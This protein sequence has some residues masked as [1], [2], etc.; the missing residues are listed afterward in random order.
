M[1]STEIPATSSL[2]FIL[3]QLAWPIR[4]GIA[5]LVLSVFWVSFQPFGGYTPPTNIGDTSNLVNQIGFSAM[6]LLVWGTAILFVPR[7][8]FFRMV[9]VSWIGMFALIAVSA[10]NAPDP[11][12]AR[13]ALTFSVIVTS[14]AAALI[15]LPPN[16]RGLSWVLLLAGGLVL[17]LSYGGVV[18]NP[19][20]AIHQAGET[21][22]QHVGLWRGVFIHKNIAGPVMAVITFSGLYMLRR[23]WRM[24]GLAFA[25]AGFVFV[26][27]TGSKTSAALVP[28]VVLMV[29]LPASLGHRRLGALGAVG[30][31]LIAHALT[32]GTVFVPFFDHILRAFDPYTTFTGRVEIWKFAKEYIEFRPLTGY[33]FAG[34]W[35]TPV[36]FNAER[37]FDQTWD[38]RFIV[39]SHNGFVDMV[40]QFGA[41]ALL[42]VA[43][44]LIIRPA[45]LYARTLR[46]NENVI[47]ADFFF[48]IVVFANLNAALES[49]YFQR[50]DPV[51]LSMVIALFGLRMTSRF[52]VMA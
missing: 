47:L 9:S 12:A 52:K 30:A 33:G 35:S 46:T 23:G 18:L 4:V 37:F 16:A 14:T 15:M 6:F 41:L 22:G 21:E 32:A 25:I 34:F 20:A 13:R 3:E 1:S 10:L 26:M 38:P 8:A 27:Q 29:W 42:P 39:H 50:A 19:A 7:A 43:W 36:V 5:A 11:D 31:I 48:M 2:G 44:L 40:L 17:G 49:F 24:A 51:W 45:L 28:A